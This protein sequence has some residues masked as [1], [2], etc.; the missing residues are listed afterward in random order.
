MGATGAPQSPKQKRYGF[1]QQSVWGTGEA[2]AAAFIEIDCDDFEI[3]RDIKLD[4][5]QNSHGSRVPSEKDKIHHTKGSTPKFSVKS[6][7]NP[8]TLDHFIYATGLAV[9]EAA[10]SPFGETFTLSTSQHDL[11]AITAITDAGH[12][13]TWIE[14]DPA[15]SK[16]IKAV[17]CISPKI[18]LIW[19]PGQPLMIEQDWIGRGVP[20]IASNPSGTWTKTTDN[21]FHF[22]DIDVVT[23]ATTP[24]HLAGL[25]LTFGYPEVEGYGQ[26]GSGSFANYNFGAPS[27]EYEIKIVK[28]ADWETNLASYATDTMIAFRVGA[29]NATPGTDDGDLDFAWNGLVDTAVKNHDK[30]M[31]GTL[32]GTMCTNA[33]MSNEAL[34]IITAN[35]IDRTWTSA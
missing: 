22:T 16:S 3:D 35:A 17:D 25:K 15:D 32:T 28:D 19:E 5:R 11:S 30:M 27:L 2:D 23:I 31:S 6:V 34:T 26:S 13:S 33:A 1:S 8:T 18:S 4:E 9:V 12:I 10:A 24:Y 21:P 29:G 14:R 7:A 20:I